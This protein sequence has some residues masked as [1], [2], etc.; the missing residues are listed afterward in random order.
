[1]VIDPHTL[2]DE[3]AELTRRAASWPAAS[4]WSA[5]TPT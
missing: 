5:R 4:C 1:M 3:I 2:L